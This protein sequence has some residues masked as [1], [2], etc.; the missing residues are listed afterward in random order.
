MLSIEEQIDLIFNAIQE[1]KGLYNKINMHIIELDSKDASNKKRLEI[2]NDLLKDMQNIKVD[3]IIKHIFLTKIFY[4]S[5]GSTLG[6]KIKEEFPTF[7]EYRDKTIFEEINYKKVMLEKNITEEFDRMF[8]LYMRDKDKNLSSP[9]Y[10]KL[11]YLTQLKKNIKLGVGL[12]SINKEQS[13]NINID[14]D[15]KE[16]LDDI[17]REARRINTD[18]E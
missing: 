1:N 12:L 11:I 18:D 8:K 3:L 9:I 4:V 10:N 7:R 13:Y 14:F 16:I 15:D 5:I 2:V 17:R 6:T